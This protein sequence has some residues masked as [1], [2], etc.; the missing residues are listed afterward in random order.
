MNETAKTDKKI[1]I[2]LKLNFLQFQVLSND[3]KKNETI[4]NIFIILLKF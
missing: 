1:I 2:S 3:I 4:F